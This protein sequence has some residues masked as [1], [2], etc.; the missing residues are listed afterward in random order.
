MECKRVKRE[1][2]LSKSQRSIREKITKPFLLA[3]LL[4]T[5]HRLVWTNWVASLDTVG[6]IEIAFEVIDDT[7]VN[8]LDADDVEVAVAAVAVEHIDRAVPLESEVVGVV[9][10]AGDVDKTPIAVG[11]EA[12]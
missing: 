5:T 12:I 4:T 6:E 10:V 8:S 9:V 1:K 3:F 11:V 7:E 2:T